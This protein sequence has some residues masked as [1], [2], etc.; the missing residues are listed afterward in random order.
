SRPPPATLHP[1]PDSGRLV[2]GRAR[3][4]LGVGI[5]AVVAAAAGQQPA[6]PPAL[7]PVAPNLARLDQTLG[8]LD[9]PGWA[10]ACADGDGFLAAGCEEGTIQCWGKDVAMGVRVGAGT[11]LVLRGHQGPVMALAWHGGP[12]LASAGADGKQ[13]PGE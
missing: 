7:P 2:M 6:P 11:P 1:L 13:L 9:G 12:V 5:L 4:W 8:G 10:L 3:F